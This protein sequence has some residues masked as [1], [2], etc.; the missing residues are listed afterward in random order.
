LQTWKSR[1]NRP[2]KKIEQTLEVAL[3][4]HK[5]TAEFVGVK[6]YADYAHKDDLI[7]VPKSAIGNTTGELAE[8][9]VK[10]YLAAIKPLVENAESKS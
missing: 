6:S 2:P 4:A 1:F 7:P 10:A 9:K 5:T 8:R 3:F